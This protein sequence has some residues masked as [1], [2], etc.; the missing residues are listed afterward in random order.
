MIHIKT[1]SCKRSLRDVATEAYVVDKTSTMGRLVKKMLDKGH[2]G[3]RHFNSEI[4]LEDIHSDESDLDNNIISQISLLLEQSKKPVKIIIG[5]RTLRDYEHL[6]HSTHGYWQRELRFQ[7]YRQDGPPGYRE[8]A[9]TI[10]GYPCTI[11]PWLEG[12]IVMDK[13]MLEVG[14]DQSKYYR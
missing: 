5:A 4:Y 7:P 13:D 3:H 9:L 14:P 10:H 11:V 6:I 1:Y 12:A 8:P 2:C